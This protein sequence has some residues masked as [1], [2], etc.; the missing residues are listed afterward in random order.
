MTS[1]TGERGGRVPAGFTLVEIL[2][3]LGLMGL[4]ATLSIAAA[5]GLFGG[6][7]A[8]STEVFW[9]A[10]AAARDLAV[11]T[12]DS[13]T[14]GVAEDKHSL[15]LR[16][17]GR[18]QAFGLP[19][20]VTIQITQVGLPGESNRVAPQANGGISHE[21]DFYGDGSCAGFRAQINQAKG[22][23]A[24]LVVDPWTCAELPGPPPPN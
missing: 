16:T 12:D 21:V 19:E 24:I 8:R 9:N 3:V 20:G 10:I 13:V 22:A 15:V 2:L 17:A 14:L 6:Q 1:A 11:T 5:T 7:A 23:A 18:N 4:L